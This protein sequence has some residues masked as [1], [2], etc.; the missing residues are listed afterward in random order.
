MEI[1]DSR[2]L[3]VFVITEPAWNRRGDGR[4][5][6]LEPKARDTGARKRGRSRVMVWCRQC[7]Q[8]L[9]GQVEGRREDVREKRKALWRARRPQYID[10]REMKMRVADLQLGRHVFAVTSPGI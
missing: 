6:V 4:M 3:L 2:K 8:G 5:L 7:T 10:E 9:G 1:G